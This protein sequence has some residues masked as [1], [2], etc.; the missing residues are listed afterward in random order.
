MSSRKTIALTRWMA[1]MLFVAG[2]ANRGM[3][4][5]GGGLG[6]APGTDGSA[7]AGAGGSGVSGTGGHGGA[8]GAGGGSAGGFI[9]TTGLG[10]QTTGAG[11][12]TARGGQTGSGGT[13]GAGGAIS[14]GGRGGTVGTTGAGGVVSS[15]GGGT[16]AGTT[17]AGGIVSSGGTVGT[18]GAGGGSGGSAATTG[19]GGVASS[20]SGGATS[21]AGGG[22]G[23][24]AGTVGAGGTTGAGGMVGAGG[25][26]QIILCVDFIGGSVPTGGTSGAVVAAPAMAATETAGVKP[27]M[28]WNGASSNMGTLGNLLEADG[29]VTA[30][31][32]TW[33]SPPLASSPGEWMNVYPDA[34]GNA[35]MMNGYLDPP[36]PTMR[37]TIT[38]SGLPGAITAGGYDV[39]GYMAGDIPFASVRTYKYTI[40]ATTFTVS[41]TGPSPATFPGFTLAPA[42]GAG[43]Y[44]IFRNVTGSSFTL[45]A[46]PGT[47][48]QTRAPVNGLQIVSPTGS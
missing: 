15:G 35:R 12:S 11:G 38:V 10:G 46:T 43:N 34:P 2:C 32:V 39:Y 23:G 9:G 3:E 1:S 4:S 44:V 6:D 33:S 13:F 30:A 18:T 40:G 42:G 45:T 17:G 29:T 36:S 37:A 27:A 19:A 20:G 31:S 5:P 26:K 14:E 22:S 16:S 21:G 7:L 25:S 8:F 24:S 47:G 28:N 41:Q 48:T